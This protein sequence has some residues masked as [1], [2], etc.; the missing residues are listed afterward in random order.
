MNTRLS[1]TIAFFLLCNA[2]LYALD[3]SYGKG[4]FDMKAGISPLFA[5]DISLDINTWRIQE[6][7]KNLSSN[8]KLYYH[9]KFD[10]FNSDTVNRITDF[11]SSPATTALPFLGSSIND[12]TDQFTQLPVP[13]DYRVSG[14]NFD[15]GL[16]YDLIKEPHRTIG[17]AV[18]TGL[19]TPF[20]RIRNLRN[21]ANLLLDVLD[22]FDTKVKTYKL[23]GSLYADYSFNERLKLSASGSVNYQTGEMDNEIVGS[24]IRI[25]GRYSTFDISL[26]YSP[27]SLKNAYLALGYNRNQWNYDS[28][29]VNT[30]VANVQV[31][32]VMDIDFDSDNVYVGVGYTF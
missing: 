26:K 6:Q 8:R 13:A 27:E 10:Y 2:P 15:I 24:G 7:H 14:I 9:F 16:G 3:I 30:P 31:P 19:S 32:R 23:G 25:D 1:A 20:M 4:Q 11:A 29:T 5:S 12:L 17:V 22:T 21:T 28:S 18:N